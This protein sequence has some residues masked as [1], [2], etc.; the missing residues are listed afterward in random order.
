MGKKLL[1]KGSS[2]VP[3]RAAAQAAN[4]KYVLATTLQYFVSGRSCT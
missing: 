2:I 1:Q 3:D 4:V